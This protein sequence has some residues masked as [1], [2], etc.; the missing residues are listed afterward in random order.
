MVLQSQVS[1]FKYYKKL[2][3]YLYIVKSLFDEADESPG[4]WLAFLT[5]IQGFNLTLQSPMAA[6]YNNGFIKN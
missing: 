1:I 4:E 5:L 2:L 6:I 3:K